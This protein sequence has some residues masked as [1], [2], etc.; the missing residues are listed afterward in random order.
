MSVVHAR[1]YHGIARNSTPAAIATIG[2]AAQQK[3][4]QPFDASGSSEQGGFTSGR[5]WDRGPNPAQ[6]NLTRFYTP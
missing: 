4:R 2:A 6:E 5:R 3:T 1:V